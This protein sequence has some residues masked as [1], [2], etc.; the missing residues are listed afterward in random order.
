MEFNNIL[1][2]I[3]FSENTDKI[4]ELAIKLSSENATITFF[5]HS[6]LI[7]PTDIPN[8]FE[9]DQ[10]LINLGEK[11]LKELTDNLSQK[12]PTRKFAFHHSFV[13]GISDEIVEIVATQ[14]IDLIVMGTHGRTGVSRL[15]MGSV[16]ED[17]L[18]HSTCP[19]FFIKIK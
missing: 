10:E 11:K 13:S 4:V 1:C 12:N 17:V 3:E 15:L 19:V 14:N 18:R 16:A 7:Y 6:V 2:P 9:T 5:H 8:G